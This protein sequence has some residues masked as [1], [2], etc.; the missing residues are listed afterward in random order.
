MSVRIESIGLGITQCYLLRGEG[1]ILVDAGSSGQTARFRAALQRL[2]VAPDQIRLIV[3]T[4]A[5]GDHAGSAKAISAL[6]GAPIAV[7]AAEHA[8]LEQGRSPL[9]PGVTGWGRALVRLMALAGDPMRYAPADAGV[10]ITDAGLSLAGYGIPGSVVHTPG[11]TRGSVSVV[12]DSGEAMVGDL[13]MAGLPLRLSPGLPVLAEDWAQ[14]RES[15]RM[16]L[17][18][19]VTT[20]YP[21]HGKPFP[22]DVIRQ[23]LHRTA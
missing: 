6:T 19:G 5:H 16:L 23:A 21:A 2:G 1:T 17:A 4:H 14:V 10:V 13:A 7:H 12:L 9:P 22:A 11:H 15:W 18:R 20:I 8:W 3:L